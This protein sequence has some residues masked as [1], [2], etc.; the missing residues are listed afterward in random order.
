MNTYQKIQTVFKRNPDDNFKTLLEGKFSIPEF[1]ML[2]NIIWQWSEK[3]DGTNLRILPEED[4]VRFK[5]KTDRA[6]IPAH[7]LAKLQDIFTFEKM[8]DLFPEPE[9]VCLYGEGYGKKI[10]KGDN[11]IKNDVG[12][13]LFDIKI[14][15]WWLTRETCEEFAKQ[16]EIPIVPI[17]GKGTLLEAVEY[18][19][20]GFKSTIAENTNYNAEGLVMKPIHDL[21]NRAGQ[22]IVAK[23][24]H[25]DF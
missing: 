9:G 21:F 22:R 3:I 13:I 1:E 10:Q 7:L 12:F 18:V 25:K 8:K 6:E 5:G 4:I 19:R 14:G 2:Q 24:K 23:I 11:Y 17:I 20:K 15:K 16:L